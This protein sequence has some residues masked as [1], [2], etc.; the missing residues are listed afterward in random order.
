MQRSGGDVLQP[1]LH[2][3][4]PI[5]LPAALIPFAPLRNYSLCIRRGEKLSKVAVSDSLHSRKCELLFQSVK[6]VRFFT[7]RLNE[8]AKPELPVA[9]MR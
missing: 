4:P 3:Q 9:F 2:P 5:D 6:C 7:Q 8:K 1:L